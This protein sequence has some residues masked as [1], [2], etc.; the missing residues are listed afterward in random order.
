M[1]FLEKCTGKEKILEKVHWNSHYLPTSR[2]RSII[3]AVC[4]S[5]TGLETVNLPVMLLTFDMVNARSTVEHTDSDEP[6][7]QRHARTPSHDD[8]FEIFLFVYVHTCC[9]TGRSTL[10]DTTLCKHVFMPMWKARNTQ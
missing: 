6:V 7:V 4:L 9:T 5:V 2:S 1:T 10:S 8:V 3:Y